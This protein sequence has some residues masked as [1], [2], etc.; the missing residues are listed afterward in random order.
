[1]RT[2]TQDDAHIFCTLDQFKDEIKKVIDLIFEMY[3]TFGF[4]KL[5][6]EL[7]TRP[8]SYTG[9]L[10]DWELAEKN[11][12]EVLTEKKIDYVLNE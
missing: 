11:L 6:I 5:N 10:A 12:K 9:E 3:N 4:T 1:V 2:F 7:S 8:E